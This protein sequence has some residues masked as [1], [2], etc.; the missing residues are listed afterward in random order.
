MDLK[1][2]VRIL[3]EYIP[4]ID[5]KAK[6]LVL[7]SGK[8]ATATFL[9]YQGLKIEVGAFLGDD[10]GNLYV[11]VGL[12]PPPKK[13]LEAFYK[14]LLLWNNFATGVGHFSLGP[15]GNPVFLFFRRPMTGLDYEEFETI[16][17][18]MAK[19]SFNV[20]VMIKQ[21]FPG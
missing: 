8:T 21:M 15:G 4:Q 3:N 6:Q 14:Q 5:R 12:V 13:N 7:E 16:V 2:S 10:E 20:L 18:N 1:A 17:V 9:Q 19:T 11:S